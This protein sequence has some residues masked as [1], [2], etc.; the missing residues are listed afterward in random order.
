ME[1]RHEISR[2]RASMPKRSTE[3]CRG[4]DGE[5]CGREDLFV[6]FL[7]QENETHRTALDGVDRDVVDVVGGVCGGEL[8]SHYLQ[9]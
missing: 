9:T 6:S 7:C 3:P 4:D 2:H 1:W 5:S 8:G